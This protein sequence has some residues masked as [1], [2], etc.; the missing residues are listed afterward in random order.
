MTPDLQLSPT[1]PCD[2]LCHSP[3]WQSL[4]LHVQDPE[5]VAAEYARQLGWD[6]LPT[7]EGLQLQSLQKPGQRLLLLPLA[8]P[9][10]K[11]AVSGPE[12]H[13]A[14]P[15]K[16]NQILPETWRISETKQ[17]LHCQYLDGPILQA[18]D[19]LEFPCSLRCWSPNL[20]SSAA[21]Y[22]QLGW[23]VHPQGEGL[24]LHPLLGRKGAIEL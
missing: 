1:L 3:G 8:N 5:A 7:P 21:F 11:R 14:L 12:H 13:W 2:P 16:L 10:Q 18:D 6:S 24:L 15:M 9:G 23:M 22:R 19:S 4:V 17:G 20:D